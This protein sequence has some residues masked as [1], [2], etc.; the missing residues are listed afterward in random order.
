LIIQ[1]VDVAIIISVNLNTFTDSNFIAT[2]QENSDIYPLYSCGY[3]T[4]SEKN[5]IGLEEISPAP[6]LAEMKGPERGRAPGMA[7]VLETPH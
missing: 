7:A 4:A 5:V 3:Y 1:T 6:N 2:E